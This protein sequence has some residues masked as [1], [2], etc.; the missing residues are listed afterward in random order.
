M[1]WSVP[2]ATFSFLLTF[3]TVIYFFKTPE[4]IAVAAQQYD[5]DK[6][7]FW[8]VVDSEFD[9]C[10]CNY[11]LSPYVA[12]PFNSITSAAYPAGAA[13][14]WRMHHKLSL[15][16]WH[17]LMLSVTAI[18]GVGSVIFHGTLR[19]W[20]Q[21]LDELPLYAM[22]ILAAA[23]LRQR[24]QRSDG[25]QPLFAGWCLVLASVL[26]FS[27]RESALHVFFRGTM[28]VSFSIAFIYI[29]TTGTSAAQEVDAKRSTTDGDVLI[30]YTI[31]SFACA[32]V[33][34]IA[35]IVG[36]RE[37][38]ALPFGL[39]YPQLHAFGWHFGTCFGLLQLF[40]LMLL[41]QHSVR[42]GFEATV[43]WVCLGLVPRV[44]ATAHQP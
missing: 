32:V 2:F 9:W 5:E 35:D 41:H 12:E 18:M 11:E 40:C 39:P 13:Y 24:A 31:M 42:D 1:H 29:F 34:W 15:S 38:Q 26:I 28:T 44:V 10:E 7:S 16:R 21:L 19:Y 20:A 30:R 27:G 36:C 4:T 43:H 22:A 23:A 14:A 25:V 17:K 33:C 3:T 37:L 8:G 6:P